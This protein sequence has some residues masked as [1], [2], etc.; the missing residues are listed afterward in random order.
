MG[1]LILDWHGVGTRDRRTEGRT[2]RPA[3]AR[4]LRASLFGRHRRLRFGTSAK[5]ASRTG[6]GRA[7]RAAPTVCAVAALLVF[8]VLPAQGSDGGRPV[9]EHLNLT[10]GD[11]V[12]LALRNNR[13]LFGAQLGRVVD[14]YSLR[15]AENRYRPHVTVGALG[16]RSRDEARGWNG[17]LG[18]SSTVVLRIPTGGEFGVRTEGGARTGTDPSGSRYS[19]EVAVTFRQPLLRGAGVGVDTAPVRTARV[20]EEINVLALGQT[21]TDIVSSVVR[22]YRSYMQAERRVEI[23]TRSLERARQLLAVNELLVRTGRMAERDIVQTRADIA[24]RELQ[25][26]AAHSGLDAARLALA[27]ILDVDSRTGI[28]LAVALGDLPDIDP[29]RTDPV[30]GVETALRHRPDYRRAL[31]RI[32]NAKTRLAVARDALRWDLSLTLS[33]KFAGTASSLGRAAGD[34]GNTDYGAR[35]DLTIP[36]G[37]AA[38]DPRERERVAAEIGLRQARNDLAELRQRIDIDVANAIRE[39]EISRRQVGLART[40]RELVEQKTD[41]EREKLRLGLSSNFR[42]VTFEDDLVAAETRELEALI[43]HLNAL[44]SLD[45]TLGTTLERWNIEIADIDR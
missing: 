27:D 10:L 12:Q 42:L 2:L 31:L 19:S 9:P 25:L 1:G 35:L 4:G 24:S 41:I 28:R 39:V 16:E 15:L 33:T 14:R 8:G 6:A 38:V 40:A 13:R 18:A 34:L 29:G 11:A 17:T 36:L 32:E 21:V 20:A 7:M 45:R 43:A 44:T 37:T 3:N 22:S 30:R 26:I 23:R 5:P